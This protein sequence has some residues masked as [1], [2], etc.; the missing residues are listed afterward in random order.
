M[1]RE[2][3]RERD[4]CTICE[5]TNIAVSILSYYFCIKLIT[6]FSLSFMLISLPETTFQR[7]VS[8]YPNTDPAG[9]TPSS[10]ST[11]PFLKLL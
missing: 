7:F 9:G 2:G 6:R 5:H 1:K 11:W 8:S 10:P 4:S 3:E